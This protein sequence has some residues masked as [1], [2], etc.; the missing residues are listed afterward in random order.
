MCQCDP[1]GA[2]R[3]RPLTSG[4]RFSRLGSDVQSPGQ[5][6]RMM[7]GNRS[8]VLLESSFLRLMTWRCSAVLL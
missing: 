6:G 7:A 1:E 4:A 5:G 2:I 3:D 8:G